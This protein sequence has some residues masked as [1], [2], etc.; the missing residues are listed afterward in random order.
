MSAIEIY[1]S[2]NYFIT[3]YLNDK[4]LCGQHDLNQN[5]ECENVL[6]DKCFL[7]TVKDPEAE[8]LIK[9]LVLDCKNDANVSFFDKIIF[10]LFF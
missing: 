10:K 7:N 3:Q 5:T 4:C 6:Q 2:N 9:K 8:A 1:A